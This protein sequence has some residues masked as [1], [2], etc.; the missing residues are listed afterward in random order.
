MFTTKCNLNS[1]QSVEE[2]MRE[3]KYTFLA[4]WVV[5]GRGR[6]KKFG[7]INT[8][9]LGVENVNRNPNQ[10]QTAIHSFFC[11]SLTNEGI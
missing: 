2:T 11:S 7:A 4:S 10:A 8:R 3:G 9:K 5:Y 1:K 6:A